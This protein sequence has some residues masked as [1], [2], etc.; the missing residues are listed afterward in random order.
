M[1]LFILILGGMEALTFVS[2]I[3][4]N[5]LSMKHTD[6]AGQG[7]AQSVVILSVLVLIVLVLPSFLLAWFNKLLWL[8]LILLLLSSLCTILALMIF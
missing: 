2:T 8:S 4:V 6:L 5:V 3:V 1:R 7:L